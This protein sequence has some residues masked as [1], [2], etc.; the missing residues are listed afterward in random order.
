[1]V[2]WCSDISIPFTYVLIFKEL[3]FKPLLVNEPLRR[4]RIENIP[5]DRTRLENKIYENT[6]NN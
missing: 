1:M 5:H 4:K 2:Y 3:R 6:A